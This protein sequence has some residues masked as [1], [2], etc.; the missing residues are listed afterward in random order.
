MTSVL[1]CYRYA[2]YCKRARRG[3]QRRAQLEEDLPRTPACMHRAYGQLFSATPSCA[4]ILKLGARLTRQDKG[5]ALVV[6]WMKPAHGVQT[7]HYCIVER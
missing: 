5:L 3:V 2:W 1:D 7:C 4:T 6:R